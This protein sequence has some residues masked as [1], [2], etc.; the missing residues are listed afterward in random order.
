[1]CNPSKSIYKQTQD[2]ILNGY[3]D[4]MTNSVNAGEN[5]KILFYPADHHRIIRIH[6]IK[7]SASHQNVLNNNRAISNQINFGLKKVKR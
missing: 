6:S 2:N 7:Q 4:K 5:L 1:M 3:A